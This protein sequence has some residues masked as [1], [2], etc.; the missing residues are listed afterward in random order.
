M[1]SLYIK[2]KISKKDIVSTSKLEKVGVAVQR[3]GGQAV[4]A[5][6]RMRL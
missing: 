4:C 2:V 3:D 6:I 5:S 1:V